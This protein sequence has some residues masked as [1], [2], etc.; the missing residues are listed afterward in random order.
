MYFSGVSDE[1]HKII[2]NSSTMKLW[3]EFVR[4][5]EA[6]TGGLCPTDRPIVWENKVVHTDATRRPKNK[7]QM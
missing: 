7:A 2:K 1:D 5:K 4:G 3:K 6:S